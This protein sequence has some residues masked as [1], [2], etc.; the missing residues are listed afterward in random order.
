MKMCS[1]QAQVQFFILIKQQNEL[2]QKI[3]Q[4]KTRIKL[5]LKKK[6]RTGQ[7]THSETDIPLSQSGH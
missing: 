3:A 2:L 7:A 5:K 4:E 6:N 1:V